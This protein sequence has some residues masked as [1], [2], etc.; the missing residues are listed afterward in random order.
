MHKKWLHGITDESNLWLKANREEEAGNLFKAF[1]L[2]LED[3]SECMK[4]DS[5]ARAALSCSCAGNCMANQGYLYEASQLYRQAAMLYEENADSVIGE[6]VRESLWLLRE[7]YQHFLLASARDGAERAF[8]K[9]I[10]LAKRISP[11]VEEESML[12]LSSIEKEVEAAKITKSLPNRQI[13]DIAKAI[14]SF[15]LSIERASGSTNTIPVYNTET[16]WERRH[17]I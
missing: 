16:S 3:A 15:L 9:Y 1:L 12:H 6:S 13:P 4:Q 7:A 8:N 14:E 17:N 11:F 5:L 2:Y 10:S